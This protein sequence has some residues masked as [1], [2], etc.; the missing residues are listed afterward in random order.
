MKENFNRRDFVKTAA[1][2][3]IGLGQSGSF[4]P[5]FGRSIA[6]SDGRIGI[7]GLNVP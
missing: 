3:G 5:A 6:A 4:S 1:I 7:V 2:G